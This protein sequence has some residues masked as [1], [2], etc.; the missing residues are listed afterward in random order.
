MP[1]PGT[2]A[3]HPM[4]SHET[5]PTRLEGLPD[6]RGAHRRRH[7]TSE[8]PQTVAEPKNSSAQL[9]VNP[10]AGGAAGF[11]DGLTKTARERGIR[12][13]VLEPGEDAS[14]LDGLV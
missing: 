10:S 3:E 14:M 7:L 4:T 1:L 5:A 8:W 13:H 2:S 11:L 9:I 6:L 12:V